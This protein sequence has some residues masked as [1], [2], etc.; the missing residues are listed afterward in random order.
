MTSYKV[1]Y[2]KKALKFMK[3]NRLVGLKFYEAFTEISKDT[4]II[5]LYDIK[6]LKGAKDIKR[7]RIGSYRALFKIVNN[8]LVI[9]V[10]DIGSRG[11]I[12]K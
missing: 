2:D 11:D 4:K 12:Y 6:N 7:L 3:E 10:I 1:K 8:E 5:S 9:L